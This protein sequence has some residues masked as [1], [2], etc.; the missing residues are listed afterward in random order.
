MHSITG[1]LRQ[2]QDQVLRTQ[3]QALTVQGQGKGQV[4][5]M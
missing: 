4:L 5:K 1:A 2:D 3:G